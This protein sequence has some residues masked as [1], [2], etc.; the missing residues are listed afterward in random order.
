MNNS[1]NYYFS[2]ISGISKKKVSP[3]RFE[4]LGACIAD[5]DAKK[6]KCK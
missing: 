2:P 3:G 4:Y 6:K 5:K 1:Q